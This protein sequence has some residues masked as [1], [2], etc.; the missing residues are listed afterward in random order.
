LGLFIRKGEF[1]VCFLQETKKVA[2]EDYMLHGLWGHQEVGWVVQE[3]VGRSGGML[4]MWNN[5]SLK[6]LSTFSGN[7]Y[8][9]IKVEREGNILFLVNIYSP[10]SLAGKKSFGRICWLLKIKMVMESGVWE[11]TLMLFYYRRKGKEVV[12]IVDKGNVFFLI[13]LWKTWS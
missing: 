6:L 12:G 1:D 4:I 13:I 3:A 10:C 9:G 8:L 5:S 11:E 7:G 2:Y